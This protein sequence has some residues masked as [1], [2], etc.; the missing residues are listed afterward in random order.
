MQSKC[1]LSGKIGWSCGAVCWRQLTRCAGDC[2]AWDHS[3]S[4]AF[5]AWR[6]LVDHVTCVAWWE[7]TVLPTYSFCSFSQSFQILICDMQKD[8]MD[9]MWVTLQSC[10]KLYSRKK[11]VVEGIKFLLKRIHESQHHELL[12]HM[13]VISHDTR[14]NDDELE[15]SLIFTD[16]HC[17]CRKDSK[18]IGRQLL[19][20]FVGERSWSW[21]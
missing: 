14:A 13:F 4:G 20:R 1:K 8:I 11:G 21:I 19:S 5:C 9:A 6:G 18:G 17:L 12:M 16:L 3:N 2:V 15:T 7:N 10:L